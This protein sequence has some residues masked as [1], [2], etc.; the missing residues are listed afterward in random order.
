MEAKGLDN[1]CARDYAKALLLYL[2]EPPYSS[3]RFG[4]FVTLDY[5]STPTA[6]EPSQNEGDDSEGGKRGHEIMGR[7]WKDNQYPSC[8]LICSKLFTQRYN[9]TRHY[10]AKHAD[11]FEKPFSCP[12]CRE[13]ICSSKQWT[14][15]VEKMHGRQHAPQLDTWRTEENREAHACPFLCRNLSRDFTRLVDHVNRYHLGQRALPMNIVSGS[16]SIAGSPT[17]GILRPGS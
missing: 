5:A 6:S 1:T 15:H 8:C 7:E 4:E 17:P 16:R 10:Q 11:L 3:T 13:D 14:S 12:L 9:L 2:R